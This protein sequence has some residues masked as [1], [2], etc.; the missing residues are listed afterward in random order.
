MSPV[1]MSS[2]PSISPL[3]VTLESYI[4]PR[5][6]DFIQQRVNTFVKWDLIRFFH[7]LPYTADTAETIAGATGRDVDTVLPALNELT[8]CGLLEA[9]SP[10]TGQTVYVLTSDHATRTLI[11]SFMLACDDSRFRIKAIYHVIRGLRGGEIAA[12]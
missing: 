2:T 4:D 12:C 6:L 5:L 9:S 11:N 3:P 7:D 8:R 1:P 10:P